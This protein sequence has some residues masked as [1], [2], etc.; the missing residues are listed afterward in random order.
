MTLS[1]LLPR[2]FLSALLLGLTASLLGGIGEARA[3]DD[4]TL[5][6]YDPDVTLSYG[7]DR[8]WRVGIQLDYTGKTWWDAAP[9]P[10]RVYDNHTGLDYPM[11]LRSPLAAAKEGVVADTE[12]GFGT[13]QFGD[14]ATSC[15]CGMPAAGTRSTTTSPVEPMVGSPSRSTRTWS[16]GRWWGCRAAAGPASGRTSISSSWWRWATTS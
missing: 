10:G 8:D 13:Q 7:V 2:R 16:R 12:G 3:T 14:S 1:R 11:S 4:Y 15:G 5:P 9:H 6:F